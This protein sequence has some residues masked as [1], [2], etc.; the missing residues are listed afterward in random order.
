MQLQGYTALYGGSFNPP[1][2]SH[3][4]AVL[5][6]LEALGASNVWLIPAAK[7]PLG[8]ELLPFEH[9]LAMCRA[10]SSPWG[11][12]VSIMETERELGGEGRTYDTI[13]HLQKQ[14]PER[15]FALVIGADI[16]E[17]SHQWY[18]WDDIHEM[19]PVVVLGREGF[20]CEEALDVRLPEVSSREIRSRLQRGESIHGLVPT[21]V[22]SYI[23]QQRLYSA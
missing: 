17:E 12:Q 3:Q 11:E 21:S 1:H 14:F 20:T 10:M 4:M 15:R 18:R 16:I 9:R 7:H 23:R 19:L 22:A 6:L 13:S 2:M 8:K 5:Y